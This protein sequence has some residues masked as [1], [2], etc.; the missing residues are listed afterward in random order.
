MSDSQIST[1]APT[2]SRETPSLGPGEIHFHFPS[3]PPS[4][5][6]ERRRKIQGRAPTGRPFS[7][8]DTM[9]DSEQELSWDG[10]ESDDGTV[11]PERSEAF[12]CQDKGDDKT[13]Q[14]A[15]PTYTR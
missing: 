7:V 8:P 6:T 13:V 3:K 11:V 4:L 15:V 2:H 12:T 10:N 14:G 1:Y 9:H 5:N